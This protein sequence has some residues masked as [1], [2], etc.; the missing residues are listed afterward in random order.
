MTQAQPQ[1]GVSGSLPRQA[2]AE[3]GGACWFLLQ[4]RGTEMGQ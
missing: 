2:Q 1:G 4:G 3:G